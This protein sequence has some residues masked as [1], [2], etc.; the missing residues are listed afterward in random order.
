MLYMTIHPG[1]VYLDNSH[2][3]RGR[4]KGTC[5]LFE[6]FNFNDSPNS[7]IH[8]I[9]PSPFQASSKPNRPGLV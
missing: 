4:I 5:E 9:R 7:P 2:L 1:V 3:R 8:P 6:S